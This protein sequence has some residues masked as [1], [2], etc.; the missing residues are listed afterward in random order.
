MS[1]G[2]PQGYV[3]SPLVFSLL[4]H[5]GT[6]GQGTNHFKYADNSTLV[7]LVSDS[8][9]SVHRR[10]EELLTVWLRIQ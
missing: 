10:K 5:D 1:R 8:D 4:T 3:L 9:E 2:S 6:A 7:E